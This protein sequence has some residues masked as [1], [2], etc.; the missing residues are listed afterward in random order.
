MDFLKPVDLSLI[1]N[2]IQPYSMY[3]SDNT[4]S[5]FLLSNIYQKPS[6]I[7][8]HRLKDVQATHSAMAEVYGC[9]K[10]HREKTLYPDYFWTVVW[11][12]LTYTEE[13]RK[14][15]PVWSLMRTRYVTR[16]VSCRV[17]AL[18]LILSIA[19][20]LKTDI[21]NSTDFV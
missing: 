4:I 7:A 9:I 15:S 3:C 2:K 19:V 21:L 6:Q 5:N 18:V 14:T 8:E 17:F 16:R 12:S 20:S 10:P 13:E 1:G 11:Y